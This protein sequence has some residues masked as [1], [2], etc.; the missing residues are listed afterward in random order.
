MTP[1][2]TDDR[3]D[4]ALEAAL[5]EAAAPIA[6]PTPLRARVLDRVRAEAIWKQ[7]EPGLEVR[8]LFYD[9]R[10][11]LVSFLLRAQ[12]G[13]I[14]PG[15]THHA[16]EECLVLEGEF[17]LGERSLRAGDFELGQI[18]EQHPDATTRT[19]V[20]VYLRGAVEDYPFAVP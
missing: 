8:T 16:V 13:A 2:P 3:L 15:H 20:L 4:P 6:P 17:I 7:V 1:R 11:G 9:G 5:L 12:P 10:A 18:G 14:M 19:G